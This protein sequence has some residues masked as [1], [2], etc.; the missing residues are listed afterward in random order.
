MH[1]LLQQP[2][3]FIGSFRRSLRRGE[4]ALNLRSE[5]LIRCDGSNLELRSA[6]EQKQL[7]ERQRPNVRRI[8]Q[9]F[10]AVLEGSPL[11][12]LAGINILDQHKPVWPGDAGHFTE[13]SARTRHMMQ[14]QPANGCIKLSLIERKLIPVRAL[15]RHIRDAAPARAFAR[16]LQHSVRQVHADHFTRGSSE[17]LGNKARAGGYIQNAF[18]A[19]QL[20]RCQQPLD[21]ALIVNPRRRGKRRSLCSER[22]A[23]HVVVVRHD[24]SLSVALTSAS[25][26][27]SRLPQGSSA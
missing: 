27:S 16:D 7:A 15:E 12:V 9:R 3:D 23:N 8:A 13:H 6:K 14:R 22:L 20:R 4:P 10:P 2:P 21:A 17:R 11:W 25:V 1:I 5:V 19:L 26:N 24:C 18:I